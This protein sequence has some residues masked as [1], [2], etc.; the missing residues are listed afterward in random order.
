M[1]RLKKELLG[2][3]QIRK[4]YAQKSDFIDWVSEYARE[5]GISM[6]VEESGKWVRSRNIILG[7][8]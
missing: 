3:Y 8:A 5:N 7:D 6:T 4:T 1:Q 2:A